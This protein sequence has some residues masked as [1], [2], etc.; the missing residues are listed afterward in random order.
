MESHSIDMLCHKKGIWLTQVQLLN[1]SFTHCAL[2]YSPTATTGWIRSAE[3]LATTLA[4]HESSIDEGA[5]VSSHFNHQLKNYE[6]VVWAVV[7]WRPNLEKIMRIICWWEP[8]TCL[9]AILNCKYTWW[10]WH[11]H[12]IHQSRSFDHFLFSIKPS[13]FLTT[14]RRFI[15]KVFKNLKK[16]SLI[17]TSSFDPDF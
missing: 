3:E 6:N 5:C 14:N 10:C 15:L 9:S 16:I 8:M 4:M 13:Y 1:Q 2:D 12:N 17:S 7:L 11:I